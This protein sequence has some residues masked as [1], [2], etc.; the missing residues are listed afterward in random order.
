MK[1]PQAKEYPYR[2]I[3][4]RAIELAHDVAVEVGDEPGVP[5]VCAPRQA[6]AEGVNRGVNGDPGLVLDVLD[7]RVRGALVAVGVSGLRSVW[8]LW[9]ATRFGTGVDWSSTC[10]GCHKDWQRY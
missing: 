1:P 10:P 8:S 2:A 7:D 6:V 9:H 4:A 5:P 3:H